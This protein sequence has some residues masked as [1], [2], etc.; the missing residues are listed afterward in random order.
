MPQGGI[1]PGEDPAEAALRELEEETGVTGDDVEIIARTPDW[2]RYDLP[3]EIV[4]KMWK[5]RYRGQEQLW[6]L[7]RF[8]GED[9]AI[10][11]ETEKPEFSRWKWIE[12]AQLIP[13]IVPFKRAV[14]EDVLKAFAARL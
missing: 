2:L 7:M 9:S 4:P 3:T 1:D 5:G 6:F 10:N 11:I 13:N 8:K 14:Y 12:P